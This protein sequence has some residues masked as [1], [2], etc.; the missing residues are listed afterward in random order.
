MTHVDPLAEKARRKMIA[1]RMTP[2]VLAAQEGILAVFV[3][4]TV[5][6]GGLHTAAS[7]LSTKRAVE[8]LATATSA[9]DLS[10]RVNDA[11]VI[12][13]MTI[14]DLCC[15][16]VYRPDGRIMKSLPRSMRR[17]I[18]HVRVEIRKAESLD[19]SCSEMAGYFDE[20]EES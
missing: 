17:C 8:D 7:W 10:I 19:V 6:V 11:Q 1:R 14:D 9:D 12:R 20:E 2:E 13:M 15:T 18:E 4:D 16:V 3:G 5:S